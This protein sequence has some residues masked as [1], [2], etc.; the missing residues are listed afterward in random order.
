MKAKILLLLFS[1]CF[2][3]AIG[4]FVLHLFKIAPDATVYKRMDLEWTEKN[5]VLNSAGYRSAESLKDRTR[6][7]FRI[8]A[9]GDSYTYGWL[10]D[11]PNDVA[12]SIIEKGLSQKLSKKVE[13]INAASP[14]F[15]LFEE[16]GRYLSEGKYY[17][18]DLILFGLNDQEVMVSSGARPW[19]PPLPEFI[20]R[21][22]LYQLTI[23]NITQAIASRKNHQYLSDIYKNE[24]S[25]DWKVFSEQILL[26]QKEA[27]KINA[28]VAIMLFPH[29]HPKNPNAAYD[30]Y[31]LNKRLA[32]FGKEHNI[33]IIDP[34]ENF[35]KYQHKEKLVVNPIDAHPTVE[36]NKLVAQAF[37][38]QFD[39]ESFL[40][41]HQSYVP[42]IDT[43]EIKKNNFSIG[44]YEMIRK[45]YSS[46]FPSY[47]YF[48][49]ESRNDTQDL[50]TADK[51]SRQTNIY[52]DRI[53]TV[54]NFTAG[55]VIGASILYYVYPKQK[56]EIVIP[57]KIY[58]YEVAGFENVYGIYKE[59]NSVA[60][61]YL[62]PVSIS[63][64]NGNFVITYNPTK[65]YYVFRLSLPVI[66]RQ[67][68]IDSNGKVENITQTLQLTKTLNEN[69]K[70]II[71]ELNQK[72]SGTPQ[73]F[74][75]P[76]TYAYAFVDD[77]FTKLNNVE[78]NNNKIILT[79]EKELK[80]GET[81]V[82]SLLASLAL[83][84]NET[85]EVEAE[86]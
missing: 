54:K 5:V 20:K 29:I 36:M 6:D 69:S 84:D 22:Y 72:I 74:T 33:F 15:A 59:G 47:A 50:P 62:N 16:I 86:R 43:V 53:Q 28:R 35:L 39:A 67:L 48:E 21:S 79:F 60:A 3:L 10:I 77:K 57:D 8:Y 17:H 76:N 52:S 30:L 70:L 1:L 41:N 12:T 23:G 55:N 63:K 46:S 85:I 51:S 31:E 2:S 19:N 45:I 11:N 65:P 26:L 58:G 9:I 82:F 40:K 66:V 61:E 13:V 24:N 42:K 68:D 25:K 49:T 34:L 37:L 73:F 18:P 56:G 38:E 14:G 44:K 75:P 4:E 32:E 78:I 7:T 64:N 80:K 83:Q 81:V 27:A 71:F